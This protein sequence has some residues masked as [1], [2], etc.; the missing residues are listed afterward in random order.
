MRWRA[1]EV[2]EIVGLAG[3]TSRPARELP[4]GHQRLLELARALA[5]RP[6][7]LLLDEPGAGMNA[8]E[9]EA[10][11]EVIHRI[12]R[13]EHVAVLLIGHTMRLVLGIS[14]RVAVLDHGVKIAEGTP[15]EIREDPL[16]VQAYLGKAEP[17]APA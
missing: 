16:V 4:F 3:E 17:G 8:D 13:D 10:L 12:H 15:A 2:L 6:R 1:H 11:T 9:L 5:S 7:L 14:H